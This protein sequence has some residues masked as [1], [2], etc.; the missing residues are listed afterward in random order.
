MFN[1]STYLQ[2]SRTQLPPTWRGRVGVGGKCPWDRCV[3]T[4]P[5]PCPPP[6]KG[7]GN[8]GS[9]EHR[10]C[11]EDGFT[12]I[13]LVVVIFI[14]SMAAMLVFPRLP[15]TDGNDLQSSARSVS[16]L[17]RYLGDK[18]ITTKSHY[19]MNLSLAE[20]AVTVTRIAG[21]EE[22][23]AEDTF[24][25]RRTL[26]GGVTIQD[27]QIP[28]L[29]TLTDDEVSLDFGAGGLEDLVIIHLRSEGGTHMTITA[30]PRNGKVQIDDGY[31][32]ME[33]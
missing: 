32:E 22:R 27:V 1:L 2:L 24:L 4:S 12:L 21:G 15:S 13:E 23:S 9:T 16:A 20:N 11:S 7:G 25:N 17:F 18:A 29:G 26:A 3:S 14:L 30:Y 10:T 33:L 28:R 8:D 5:A 19:R 31:Q 6:V